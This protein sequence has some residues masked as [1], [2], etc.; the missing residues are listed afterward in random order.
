M[1][2]DR[3]SEAQPAANA[4]ATVV[5]DE[6][7]SNGGDFIGFLRS[8]IA[9]AH[10]LPGAVRADVGGSQ[11]EESQERIRIAQGTRGAVRKGGSLAVK[12]DVFIIQFKPS[13]TEQQIDQLISKYNLTVRDVNWDLGVL[14]VSSERPPATRS[15]GGATRSA[16]PAAPAAKSKPETLGGLLEPDVL[17]KI[18]KEPVVNAAAVHSTISP[19]ALPRPSETSVNVDKRAYH[20]S[21]RP[22]ATNDGNWGLKRLRLPPVWQVLKTVRAG[23]NPGKVPVMGF[24]DIGFGWHGHLQYNLIHGLKPGEKP[25]SPSATCQDSHGTHVA[26]IAGA[27]H[28]RG[29][30]ID[31]IVPDAKVDAIPLTADLF[32]VGVDAGIL[33]GDAANQ[34]AVLFMDAL[35]TLVRYLKENPVE[36]GRK[37][38]INVSLGF[39]WSAAGAQIANGDLVE[40]SP[41]THVLMACTDAPSVVAEFSGRHALHRGCGQRLR[42]PR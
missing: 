20:W 31:G 21:W 15:I 12:K 23:E 25:F 14:Y 18:R 30:G 2:T 41:K 39:N 10:D 34:R 11:T 5:S 17:K 37:R 32:F 1:K 26:G 27:A 7:A 29:R 28:G 38:V 40:S 42:G 8:L 35:S 24:L 6:T 33:G 3:R 36:E 4:G 19:K 13:T 22:D 16:S 9:P